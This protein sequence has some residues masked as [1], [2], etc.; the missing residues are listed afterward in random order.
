MRSL[1]T[2]CVRSTNTNWL[3]DNLENPDPG[4][5]I[6]FGTLVRICM[7]IFVLNAGAD[8]FMEEE[9]SQLATLVPDATHT[10][11]V[12]Y[13]DSNNDYYFGPLWG[14]YHE[15][16]GWI[17]FGN[18]ALFLLAN[19][20]LDAGLLHDDEPQHRYPLPSQRDENNN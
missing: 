20:L 6:M 7:V 5:L 10:Y 14:I 8:M 3:R 11:R 4:T 12:H 17:W 18:I 19:L 13:T 2:V 9:R 16:T 1:T 15:W